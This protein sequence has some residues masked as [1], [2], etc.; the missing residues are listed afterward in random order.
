VRSVEIVR[1][2]YDAFARHGGLYHAQ[3]ADVSPSIAD[4]GYVSTGRPVLEGEATELRENAQP[5]KARL[6]R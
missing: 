3:I 6:G 4:R 1:R 5:R 2:S